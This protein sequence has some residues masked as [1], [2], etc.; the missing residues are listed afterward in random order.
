MITTQMSVGLDVHARSVAAC[1]LDRQSGQV[2]EQRLVP[3]PATVIEW[4]RGL[5]GS[6]VVTYEAGPT[7]YGLARAL[8]EAGIRCLVA[9]PSKLQRPAGDRVK[10]DKRDAR[11]LARLLHLSEIV[12]VAVPSRELEACRDLTRSREAAR[13]DLMTARHRLLKLLLRHGLV[14]SDGRAWTARHE[15]WLRRQRLPMLH[16]QMAF[17]SAYG[18]VVAARERRDRLDEAI[19]QMAADCDLTPVVHRL[20]CLRGISTLTGFGLAVEVGDWQRFS[21]RTI[22]A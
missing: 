16:S 21:G 12:E 20:G 10:T 1:G 14:F 19:E 2:F 13:R 6:A 5:P 15:E 9:A 17:E 4:V 7:G 3:D 18:A 11:H 22:G 8:E